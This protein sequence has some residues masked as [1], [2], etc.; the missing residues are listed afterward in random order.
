VIVSFLGLAASYVF[1]SHTASTTDILSSTRAFFVAE[2]GLER[3]IKRFKDNCYGSMIL[4]S[5][6]AAMWSQYSSGVNINLYGITYGGGLFVAVGTGGTIL[7]STNGTSWTSRTSGTTNQLNGIAY[8]NLSGTNYFVA[9]GAGGTILTSTNGTSWTSRT[10]GTTNQLNGIA[11]GNLSGTNYFVA[12]GAG[13][14]ILTSTNGTSWTSRASGTTNNINGVAYGGSYFFAVGNS[15]YVRRS[16]NGS[17]WSAPPNSPNPTGGIN[18]LGVA[19]RSTGTVFIITGSNGSICRTTRYGNNPSSGS[20]TYPS[21]GTGNQLN[22]VSYGAAFVSVG[23]SGTILTST[24]GTSWNA[25]TSGTTIQ[26][27]GAAYG[28][29]TYIAVGNVTTIQINVDESDVTLGPGT[30]TVQSFATDSSGTALTSSNQMRIRSKGTVGSA[31]RTVEQICTCLSAGTNEVTTATTSTGGSISCGSGTCTFSWWPF[32]YTG[33]CGCL[34]Q[35]NTSTFPPVSIP[36]PTPNSP[37]GICEYN[38]GTFTWD[39]GTYY[40]SSFHM[41]SGSIINLGGPVTIYTS[42]FEMNNS[43]RLNMNGGSLAA[44]LIVMITQGG[45]AQ[46]NSGSLF[47]GYLYA[48]GTSVQTNNSSQ[49]YGSVTADSLTMNSSSAITADVTAGGSTTN[50]IGISVNWRE[51]R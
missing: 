15:E 45:Y 10:S 25:G 47:K 11:Y 23:A 43:S 20:W 49:I 2:G 6:D 31:K 24:D 46:L 8:G 3:G 40:C 9:V 16:S 37:G 33:D 32:G 38:G 39:A 12:V 4:T 41:N 35:N 26:L 29:G 19:Y 7:T 5:S 17:T 48:P 28:G 36:V 22:A 27:N 13:G 50:D 51:V 21:S 34:D 14:T 42:S 44:N 30:F 18:F 1:I